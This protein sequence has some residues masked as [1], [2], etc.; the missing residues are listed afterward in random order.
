[1]HWPEELVV[2]GVI[3][4]RTRHLKK[5]KAYQTVVQLMGAR[6]MYEYWN[7]HYKV[8]HISWSQEKATEI[9]TAWQKKFSAEVSF[10]FSFFHPF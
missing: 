5:A 7:E 8:H 9:L 2:G 4:N 6:E 3:R 10:C 1:M